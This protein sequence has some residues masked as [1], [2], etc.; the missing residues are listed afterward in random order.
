LRR[1]SSRAAGETAVGSAG[2]GAGRPGIL[3]AGV[4]GPVRTGAL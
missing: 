1:T 4:P 3:R 2:R